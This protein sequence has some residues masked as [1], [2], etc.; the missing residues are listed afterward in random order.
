M[1]ILEARC[2]ATR[3]KLVAAYDAG[4]GDEDFP[5]TELCGKAVR[6]E[7]PTAGHALNARTRTVREAM[8]KAIAATR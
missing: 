4:R 6:N 8:A 5:S 2:T 7:K 3:Q 1:E